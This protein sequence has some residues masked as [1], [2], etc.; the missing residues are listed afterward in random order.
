MTYVLYSSSPMFWYGFSLCYILVNSV[1]LSG[2]E[3]WWR[4]AMI[5]AHQSSPCTIFTILGS[6][7]TVLMEG[8]SMS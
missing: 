3:W 4:Y 7:S 5:G 8:S 1:L 2:L 6:G